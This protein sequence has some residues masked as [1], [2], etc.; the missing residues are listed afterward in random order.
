[1]CSDNPGNNPLRSVVDVHAHLIPLEPGRLEKIPGVNL[2]DDEHLELD[3]HSLKL[4]ALYHPEML[5]DW[6]DKQGVDVALISVPPPA[7]RQHLNIDQAGIWSQYL[8]DGL[9]AI[10]NKYPDRFKVL[11]HLPV[12]HPTLAVEEFDSRHGGLYAGVALAA[13]GQSD[14]IYSE[15]KLRPLWEKLNQNSSFVFLHPG[16][17]GDSRLN[18]FYCNN[19]LGNPYETAVAAAHLVFGGVVEEFSQIKFCLAHCGGVVPAVAGRW[20]HGFNT[21]RPGLDLLREPPEQ[22][23]RRFYVDTVAHSDG[24]ID[25]ARQVFGDDKIL[26]GSD[27]PF[28]MGVDVENVRQRLQ[29]FEP[30]VSENILYKNY[31]SLL[32]NSS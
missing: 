30:E 3:G 4:K 18:A 24:L 7:Y 26:F 8:N 32:S 22:S 19:L 16:H 6:M 15:E 31:Q 1:M 25:L 21:K 23:L 27:W 10:A 2:I 28:P 14:I 12:E 29:A 20:Q 17:C 5:I 13:G 9:E 11:A